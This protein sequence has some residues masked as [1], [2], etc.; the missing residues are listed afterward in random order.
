MGWAGDRRCLGCGDKHT[1]RPH[2]DVPTLGHPLTPALGFVFVFMYLFSK[3]WGSSFYELGSD[4]DTASLPCWLSPP[5]C[6][7]GNSFHMDF[8][9]S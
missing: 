7:H 6:T 4:T 2:F 1:R 5:G 3:L 9:L 8:L